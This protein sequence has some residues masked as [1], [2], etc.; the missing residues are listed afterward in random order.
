MDQATQVRTAH[1]QEECL[2]VKIVEHNGEIAAQIPYELANQMNEL[3][4]GRW[5]P[6]WNAWRIP[7]GPYAAFQLCYTFKDYITH[8][9]PRI[10]ELAYNLYQAQ[11]AKRTLKSFL[12]D[13]DNT[14][15]DEE[16][17]GLSTQPWGHQIIAYRFAKDLPGAILNMA[18]GTGK[19]LTTISL[20]TYKQSQTVLIVCPKSVIDV[21]PWEF[22]KHSTL[23]VTICAP[24]KGT[25]AQRAK[26]AARQLKVAKARKQPFILLV[27]YESYW[28]ESFAKFITGMTWDMV[29]YDEVHRLK[30][31]SGK[32][33]K[34]AHKL[35]SHTRNRLGLTGTLIPHSP[36]DPFSQFK[37][38]SP[39]I[40]GH[41]YF[42]YR[43]MYAVM[44]GFGNKQVVAYK[45]LDDMQDKLNAI[46]IYIP[47]TVLDLMDPIHTFRTV[48][49][50][51]QTRKVYEELSRDFYTELE[52]GSLS[53]PNAMVK[54]LRLQQLTSGYLKLEN[55]QGVETLQHYGNEKY[56]LLTE[57]LDELPQNEP[58]VLCAKFTVD[59]Q[60]IKAACEATGRSC[61]ELS[62]QKN[63]LRQWQDGEM[64][65]LAVQINA[66]KEGI[67]LT[68]ARYCVL[69]SVGHS[70]GAYE[71]F[72]ARTNRPGQL[73]QVTYYHLLVSQSVDEQVYAALQ[74]R[75]EIVDYIMEGVNRT[76]EEEVA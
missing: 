37:A 8:V 18:M 10:K 63:E 33:G 9:S 45:N 48:E 36:L 44:G 26:E 2:E 72:L 20:I 75:K 35:F 76:M 34:F 4:I 53:V 7:F 23:E 3:H 24:K 41:N 70:L 54:V 21:W 51:T 31:H 28:R 16:L 65:C 71:Q 66:G 55:D 74:K 61:A 32:Q 14:Q 12:E 52:Q 67:D 40:F 42:R 58:L 13:P 59:I 27:N 38:V 29:V 43:N 1:R 69:Y 46:S 62:G 49:L 60:N 64:D 39:D 5:E 6:K 15:V 22:R 30:D 25:T 68:R 50:T 11:F 56:E 19:T 17:P 73:R 57:L 47:N